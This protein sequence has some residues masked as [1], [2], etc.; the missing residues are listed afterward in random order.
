[1]ASNDNYLR[2]CIIETR[3]DHSDTDGGVDDSEDDTDVFEN[4]KK[5]FA[6]RGQCIIFCLLSNFIGGKY[7]TS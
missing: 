3:K 1:M 7:I 4:V 5:F 6:P 2:K